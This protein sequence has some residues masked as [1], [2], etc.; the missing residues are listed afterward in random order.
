MGCFDCGLAFVIR[1]AS[2]HKMK[3]QQPITIKNNSENN[4]TAGEFLCTSRQNV[5]RNMLLNYEGKAELMFRMK[6]GDMI[7]NHTDQEL[8]TSSII[9]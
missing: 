8:Y 6:K 3:W 1:I 5:F 9:S 4:L 2:V 7:L